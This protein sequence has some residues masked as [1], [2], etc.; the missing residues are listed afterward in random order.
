M[1]AHHVPVIEKKGARWLI[2][3][4]DYKKGDAV[5]K[6]ELLTMPNHSGKSKHFIIRTS[7][8]QKQ[9]DCLSDN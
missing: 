1:G 4:L 6:T 3:L 5:R 2:S 7:E 8:A 9:T